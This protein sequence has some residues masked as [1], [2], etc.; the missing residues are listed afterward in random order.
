[1][2]TNLIKG[3]VPITLDRDRT[4]ILDWNAFAEFE[5]ED[6][7]PWDWYIQ[8]LGKLGDL[9]EDEQ[10]LK[11]IEIV[12]VRP[13]RA[14]LWAGLLHSEPR[15]TLKQAGKLMEFAPGSSMI[16]KRAYI[17]SKLMR[18][19]AAGLPE[20]AKKNVQE[21]ME[22]LER[23]RQEAAQKSQEVDGTTTNG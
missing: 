16:E 5:G 7:K 23:D 12:G 6:G 15:M 14:L 21:K 9:P 18:A 19:W 13:M 1:M 22:Q 8:Q 10:F 2:A 20:E 3:E 17:L 11:G 4:L